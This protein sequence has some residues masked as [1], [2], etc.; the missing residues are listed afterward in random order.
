M[1]P[2]MTGPNPKIATDNA[3]DSRT[4]DRK[5]NN[6]ALA[7]HLVEPCLSDLRVLGLFEK[8]RSQRGSQSCPGVTDESDRRS[9]N[10]ILRSTCEIPRKVS[11]QELSN[12]SYF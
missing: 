6:E 8:E 2:G 1:R 7:F 5:N 12:S 4:T 3:Q 9:G 10:T 11:V